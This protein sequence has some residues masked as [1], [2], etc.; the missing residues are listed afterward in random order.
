MKRRVRYSCRSEKDDKLKGIQVNEYVVNAS[1]TDTNGETQE[2]SSTFRVASV[3]HFIETEEVKPAF[4]NEEIK[5]KVATKN[6]NNQKLGKSYQAKL[7]LLDRIFR[8]NFEDFVQDV[9]VFS[10]EN[11]IQKFPHDYFDKSELANNRK[12]K[13]TVLQKQLPMKNL[14]LGNWQQELTGILQHRR[15]GYYKN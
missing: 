7:S 12:E 6:Y 5:V 4:A 8:N 13:Q 1:V 9:P 14:V 10:K 2:N 3:S 11:F 15:T